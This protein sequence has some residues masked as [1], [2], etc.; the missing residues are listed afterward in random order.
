MKLLGEGPRGAQ[1]EAVLARGDRRTSSLV[2]M[3][4]REG[5]PPKSALR[6]QARFYAERGRPLDEI[7]PWDLIKSSADKLYLRKEWERALSGR[8]DP[9]CEVGRCSRCGICPPV[10]QV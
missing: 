10:R 2:E 6:E 3:A 5:N 7:L 1:L 9:R 4:F 8:P